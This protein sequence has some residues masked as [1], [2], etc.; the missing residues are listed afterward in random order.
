MGQIGMLTYEK[1]SVFP[2]R[3]IIYLVYSIQVVKAVLCGT[4]ALVHTSDIRQT[5]TEHRLGDP[6]Q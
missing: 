6:D 1:V 5:N 4:M 2:F 3:Y